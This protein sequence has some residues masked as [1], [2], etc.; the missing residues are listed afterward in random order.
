MEQKFRVFTEDYNKMLDLVE[1]VDAEVANKYKKVI[2]KIPENVLEMLPHKKE[3]CFQAEDLRIDKDCYD[4]MIEFQYTTY[5]KY[6]NASLNIYPYYEDELLE[7]DN[8]EI[9][10]DQEFEEDEDGDIFIF[11]LTMTNTQGEAKIKFNFEESDGEYNFVG[12]E[13]NGIELDYSVFVERRE[14]DFYLVSRHKL[15]GIEIKKFEKPISYQELVEYACEEKE[16]DDEC[17]FEGCDF[18]ENCDFDNLDFDN[19][20]FEN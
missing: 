8:E 2:S 6:F 3:F 14:E 16:L 19:L 4:E 18:E 7:D 13:Q 9:Y 5:R 11:S 15:N 12:A 20:D 17:D 1:M 10:V